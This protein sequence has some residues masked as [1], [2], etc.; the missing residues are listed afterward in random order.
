MRLV[1][2]FGLTTKK[3]VDWHRDVMDFPKLLRFQGKK[4][5]WAMYNGSGQNYELTFSLLSSYDSTFNMD[6]PSFE[7]L[8]EYGSYNKCECGAVY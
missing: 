3:E 8:F 7:D 6:M 4:W 2:S 1:I 5:E